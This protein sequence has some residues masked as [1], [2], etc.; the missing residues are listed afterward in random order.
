MHAQDLLA[1]LQI[2]VAHRDLP[3]EP[4]RAQQRRIQNVGPVGRGDDDDAVVL[5]E[6][7]HLHQELVERLFA[8]FVAQGVATARA[9]HGVEL[10][11]E[12]D[13]GAVA[14]G[15]LEQLAD[16]RGADA[17]IHLDEVGAAR[18]DERH[19]CLARHR[20]RQQR[21]AGAGRPHEQ[22]AARNAAANRGELG[23]L[24]QELDDLGHLVL[25]LVHA[26]DVLERDGHLLRIDGA[27]LLERGDA[28][29]HHTVERQTR[30]AEEQQ[31]DR[32]CAVAAGTRR[33]APRERHLNTTAAEVG[34]EGGIACQVTG[35]G[36]GRRGG[37]V[38]TGELEVV[39]FGLHALHA[40]GSDVLEELRER[41]DLSGGRA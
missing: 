28:A 22:D 35:W 31:P 21:L 20:S 29:G 25:R 7:V 37:P 17:R 19:A 4:S 41:H 26:G 34:D 24:L 32:E 12:D 6:A 23:R 3:I 33:L 15:F 10:V 13:A 38:G 30:E 9:A 36:H 14:A 1:T 11:D 8:L 5:A 18:G 39:A 16:A 40:V 27:R 2:R